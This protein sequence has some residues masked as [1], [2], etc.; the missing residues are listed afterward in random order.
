MGQVI[1]MIISIIS[2]VMMAIITGMMIMSEVYAN[3]YLNF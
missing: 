1:K 2:N 3:I